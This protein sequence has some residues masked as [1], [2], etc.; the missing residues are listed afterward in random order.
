MKCRHHPSREA[1]PSISLFFRHVNDYFSYFIR[2]T[3]DTLGQL[4]FRTKASLRMRPFD[5]DIQNRQKAQE[6]TR[7]VKELPWLRLVF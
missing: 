2:L 1:R 7:Q 5:S 3:I 6:Y 4:S